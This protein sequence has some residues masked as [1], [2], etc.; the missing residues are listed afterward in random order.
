VL[1][2]ACGLD[3]RAFR[4][5]LPPGVQWYDVDFS[6][7]IDLRKRLYPERDNHHLIGS[8]VTDEDWLDQIPAGRPT[9]VIA[10][11]L[12]MY[13]ARS[14]VRRL[15]A[16]LTDRFPAGQLIL[17]VVSPWAA[18]S[19][20]LAGLRMWGLTDPA[21]WSAGALGWHCSTTRR[22]SRTTRASR[23]ALT[24]WPTGGR[25]NQPA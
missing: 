18:R 22:G 8:S 14:E 20:V 7:V 1:Q 19:A 15:V 23:Y 12:V 13:L 10:E 17:D 9:L 6:D 3:S 24:Q 16:R 25:L 2:L 5:E 4:L 11:G 21:C